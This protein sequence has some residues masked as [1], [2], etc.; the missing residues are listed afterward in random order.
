MF[1]PSG[2]AFLVDAREVSLNFMHFSFSKTLL[3]STLCLHLKAGLPQ[4]SVLLTWIARYRGWVSAFSGSSQMRNQLS[5]TLVFIFI[6]TCLQ[7]ER[8]AP[9]ITGILYPCVAHL[10]SA[11]SPLLVPPHP[12][13]RSLPHLQSVYPPVSYICLLFR[14]SMYLYFRLLME[15]KSY[16][17]AAPVSDLCHLA[18][19]P[20]GPSTFLQMGPSQRK[21]HFLSPR[22]SASVKQNRFMQT[23]LVA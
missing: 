19:G 12:I 2:S 9:F 14:F 23:P 11:V 10:N 15:E 18:F 3:K 4:S 6:S 16:D 1:L 5:R 17:I 8:V 7:C 22:P 21:S 13:S 20:Q